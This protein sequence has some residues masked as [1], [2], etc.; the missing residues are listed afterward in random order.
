MLK[1]IRQRESCWYPD[2]HTRHKCP[3]LHRSINL[4]CYL[5]RL[6]IASCGFD[7]ENHAAGYL[8][9]PLRRLVTNHDLHGIYHQCRRPLHH[10]IDSGSLR[11][12]LVSML[13]PVLD[14]GLSKGRAG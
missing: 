11:G 9:Y 3:I 6:R 10:Q 7:E 5:R 1:L 13:E 12:W 2:R 4:L 14:D 8:D